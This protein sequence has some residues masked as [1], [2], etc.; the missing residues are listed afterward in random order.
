MRN[1]N[2]FDFC[3]LKKVKNKD[4]GLFNQLLEPICIRTRENK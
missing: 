4:V 3:L 1:F 2:R